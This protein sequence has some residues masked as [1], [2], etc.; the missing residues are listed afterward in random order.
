MFIEL[1]LLQNFAPSCLNRDDTNTPKDCEFGGYRRARI[2]SQC[3]KRAVRKYFTE[4]ALLPREHCATR[5]KRLT[6]LVAERL[7][8]R[9]ELDAVS[10]AVEMAL[11]ALS[12]KLEGGQTQYLMFLGADEVDRLA[13]VIEEHAA[14]LTAPPA[15][16][17][18][19]AETVPGATETPPSTPR[20]KKPRKSSKQ[21]KQEA[22][23]AVPDAV[24]QAMK[25]VLGGSKAADLALFGR[26]LADRTEHNIDG[27][28]QVAHALSTNRVNIEMDFYTAVDDWKTREDDRGAGMLGTVE[29][30]SACFYRYANID[31][32]QLCRN[33][34][35]DQELARKTVEAFLRAMIRAIPTGKQNSMAAHNPPSLILAVVRD[36]DLWS[37]TNAFLRPVSPDSNGDLVEHSAR[38]LDDH[39]GRLVR[40]YGR[41]R[42]KAGAVLFEDPK[43]KFQ[44]LAPFT[45]GVDCE[46]DVIA[47]VMSCLPGGA[48]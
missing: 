38:R 48:A 1:H 14:V 40:M 45:E 9:L 27:A 6:Q 23:R 46:S 36:G 10:R 5:T 35:D 43:F 18:P 41:D 34:Q 33:L 2:S 12:M 19:A 7:Q 32:T 39:W 31:F 21:E 8:G 24:I 47:R 3:Q 28:C 25:L 30:V 26:M 13:R 42:L 20:G 44:H 22:Q 15:A 29:F 16:P 37:L 17:Q 4:Q 11:A